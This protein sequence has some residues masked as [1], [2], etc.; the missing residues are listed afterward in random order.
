M[1]WFKKK[2]AVAAEPE[3]DATPATDPEA[4]DL[5]PSDTEPST[6]K[7]STPEAAEP[8]AAGPQVADPTP[9]DDSPPP[10]TPKSPRTVMDRM[11]DY[12]M[13]QVAAPPTGSTDALNSQIVEA[14]EFTNAQTFSYAPAQIAIAPDMMISQAAGLVAQ[15]AAGYFDGVSKLALAAQA[16]L[17]EQMTKNIV[18]NHP[19]KAAEDALGAL[20]TDLLVGAAAAV[21]A[22][23]GALEATAAGIAIDKI[24]E[25][26]AKYSNTLANRGAPPS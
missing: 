2:P 24:D 4:A 23:A 5:K 9:A 25:S 10:S 1:F 19:E 15:S 20:A 13:V 16:V 6:P 8:T 7:P 12:M 26:I 21:A 18:E 22:A 3:T 17:L 14:V 11:N